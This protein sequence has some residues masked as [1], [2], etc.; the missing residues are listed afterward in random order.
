[1]FSAER[2]IKMGNVNSKEQENG[3]STEFFPSATGECNIAVHTWRPA[4]GQ[5]VR[6]VIQLVHGMSEYVRRFQPI[7]EYF[8]SLGYVFCGNDHAGHGDSIQQAD[9]KGFF[10][11][12]NGWNALVDDVM[13]VHRRLK[14][15]YP[16]AKQI[17]YG[18]SMGSFI[19]R[20]CASRYGTEFDA[21][22][23]SATAGKNPLLPFAKLAARAEIRRRGAQQL[24]PRLNRLVF[25]PYVMSVKNRRTAFDWLSKDEAVVDAYAE[26]DKLRDRAAFR[27]W[28]FK[29]L[30]IKCKKKIRGYVNRDD[31]LDETVDAKVFKEAEDIAGKVDLRNAF[32]RLDER[33]RQILTLSVIAGYE[34]EE[35]SKIMDMNHN[36]VR[37]I[38]SRALE[39]MRKL[40]SV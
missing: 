32:A 9:K 12:E 37:T 3:F 39:K 13:T 10:A 27:S 8:V 31:E 23:F 24:S 19:A 26:F 2:Q 29:I 17:L 35:V 30:S 40:L 28:I 25:G 21:F 34:G 16:E 4:A 20:A 36:T 1:M 11:A 22:I 18:H 5:S 33:E 38:K 14:A 15:E 7:A 6:G